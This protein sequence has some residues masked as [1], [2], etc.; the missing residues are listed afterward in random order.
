[1]ENSSVVRPEYFF[2]V[3]LSG[4]PYSNFYY[5]FIFIIYFITMVGNFLVILVIAV[6]R[7]LHSPKYFGVFNLALADIG[8]TNALIP[9]MMKT[10]LFDSPYI[11]YNVCLVNM[12]FVF[13]FSSMQSLTLVVMAYDRF[14]AICLPLRYH[15]IVNNTSMTLIFSSMF[16]FNSAIVSSMVSLV[17]QISFCRTNAIQSYFCDH[18][19]MFRMACNDNNINKIMGFLY[20]TLYLIAPML[21]IFLSYVGIVYVVSQIATWEGRL[22]ALKTCVSHLLLVG[23]YFLPI[24]FTYLT[25]LL[26]YST[27]NSRVIS[28]SLAY[29]VPS[30]L[31]PIIYNISIVRPEY[32]FIIGLSGIPYST[33]YYI[34]LFI[35]YFITLMG[36]SV[37]L[38]FIA[39]NRSLHSPKYF[40]VFNLALADIGE[41]N[42]LIPN[43]MKTFL[44]GSQ[45]ISYNDCL[46]NMFFVFLF[47]TIQSFTL[48][49]MAYDRF[50]AICLPLRYHALV[51]NTSMLLVF[52]VIWT[53]NSSVVL[54]MV[55]FITRL[56]FCQSNMIQSYF[57]DHG[58]VYRLA[59]ND[60]SINKFMAFLFTCLFLLVPMCII[61][62]SY[63]GIG[64]ALT[65]ITTWEER[66]K[67]LKTCVCHLL[68]VGCL[69]VPLFCTYLAQLLLSLNP[70]AR[71]I[72]TSLAY[73]V[74]PMLNPIIYVL[75]TVEIKDIIHKTFKRRVKA[76]AIQQTT[77]MSSVNV[78]YSPNTSIVHPEYFFIVGLS[79]I[80]FSNYYYIFL[81]VV[82][83]ITIVG[84][85]V[86]LLIIALERS[87]HSP[88]YFGVFHLALADI[89]ETNA[90]I[91]NMMKTF[92]FDSHSLQS[93]TLVI[94][95][96]DR[97]VAICLPL[98][99][100][101]IVSNSS[102]VLVFPAIWAFNSSM[103]ALMVSLITRL[104]ICQSNAI[105]SYFCD[106]GPVYRLGC[107]DFNLNKSVGF[108]ITSLFLIS[109][110]IIIFLS[111][112]TIFLALSKITTWERRLK[113]LKTCVSHLLLVGIYFLPICYTYLAQLL[114]A[115]TPNARVISTSLSYVVPA[116]LN[117]IIY[118]LNTAEIKNILQKILI[119][120]KSAMNA[121]VSQNTSIIHPE[122]FFISGLSGIPYAS[123]YYVFLFITYFIT[124]IGNSVVLLIIAVD[125]RLHSPKY[126]G[127]FH[128]ALADFGE[129]N[130]L[131]PNIMK[132]FLFD[133]QYISYNDCLTN[134][135]FVFFFNSLQSVT[136]VVMAYDRLVAICLPLRYHALVSN[137]S[138]LLILSAMWVFNSSVVGFMV[139]AITRLSICKSNVVQSYFCDHGPIFR[140][141]CNNIKMSEFLAFL[142][143]VLYITLP[144][145][146]IVISYMHIFHALTK[147]TSWEGRLK[148]LKTC[149][150]HLLLAGMF[151]LPVACSYIAQV[152]F[153][154]NPNA[155]VIST[156]LAYAVPPMLN[157]IIY[158]LNT[159][160]IKDIMR[161]LL[162]NRPVPITFERN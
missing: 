14:I 162:K 125:R 4:I 41:T 88:K 16:L 64:L 151:F 95:A 144:M 40:G 25:S 60:F 108:V 3:G 62:L 140:L 8:E 13:L 75:N 149:V 157:P 147:I 5:I 130:A 35:T 46:A 137:T 111:Y 84:N 89:G 127:V 90:L 51:N 22:K 122:Y 114:L 85:S 27:P 110:M 55:A 37:V 102:M 28:T 77:T 105:Q 113:A 68:L 146:I 103:V 33:Y 54:L 26:L 141:A 116:M 120:Q 154:L 30:M 12:F 132:T 126:I 82:Y 131:I 17:T 18:G 158:V 159:A 139:S 138:L 115:L 44:F 152:M 42:A 128:L 134:M 136:L 2:I 59:C 78:S 80:P 92:L 135:F 56:S 20:T 19:P 93:V 83:F 58:P 107:N 57:C 121:S 6:D 99:Y 52:S 67:A 81:F 86:V 148:A 109:P 7:R 106:H 76:F 100:H 39:F 34:F 97:L 63:L 143:P 98:R 65:R 72:S 73:A 94:M 31:N 155:R 23:I 24:F 61:A 36:N 69:F 96:Y 101:A 117:P 21:V 112:L 53:F 123:Y 71:V 119:E 1:M 49:V 129:T 91:P 142:F 15:V 156:S 74:P 153:V 38:L 29:T 118:V 11:S 66:F 70:N 43:M 87:L 160:E 150:S 133:S 47:S 79:G 50:V 104:S 10:F 9:N 161:K 45:Y 48:V 32:F 145:V 124:V